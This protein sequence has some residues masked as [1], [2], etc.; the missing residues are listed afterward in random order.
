MTRTEIIQILIN[1]TSAKKYLEIGMGPGLNFN[2]IV[3]EMKVCV[4]PNPT[5]PV[6]YAITSNEFFE[7]NKDIFD[8]IFIDGLHT[9]EQVL[10]DITN[11]L[12]CLSDNGFIVCHDM[13][14]TSEIMQLVPQKI[15]NSAWTGDCWKAWVK[16]KTERK[17]LTMFVVDTDFGCG[18]ICRGEQELIKNNLDLTWDY[19]DKNKENL[20]NFMS[21]EKFLKVYA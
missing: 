5:V 11:S 13:N 7:L 20:L 4:D 21:V 3:C 14:P 8:V 10:Q 15:P 1:K 12:S 2:S 9:S 16:L 18:V 6:T 17:D 19:F